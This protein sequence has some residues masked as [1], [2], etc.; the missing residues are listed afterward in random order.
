[1][2]TRPTGTPSCSPRQIS[3][4][5]PC[6]RG[7]AGWRP[8]GGCMT[9][10]T[11]GCKAA[12]WAVPAQRGCLPTRRGCAWWRVTTWA[13][14][15]APYGDAHGAPYGDAHGAPYGDAH[16]APYGDAHGA[17]YG[18]AHGAPYGDAH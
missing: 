16:G 2:A 17:P 5:L 1:M 11:C 10:C 14:H 4:P 13:A 8:S 12:S 15:G 18:D 6:S 3:P 9:P 7:R